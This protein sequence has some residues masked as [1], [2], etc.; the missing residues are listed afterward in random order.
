MSQDDHS[1]GSI[2]S[3]DGRN[4]DL[5]GICPQVIKSEI[6]LD[7]NLSTFCN[8]NNAE[9]IPFCNPNNAE[10]I[11]KSNDAESI[12]NSNANIAENIP[13]NQSS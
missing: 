2:L 8:A 4:N 11:P 6:N 1:K 3:P 7:Q 12:P 9:I 13:V 10:N 5:P